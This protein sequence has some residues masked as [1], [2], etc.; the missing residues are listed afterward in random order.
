MAANS[1]TLLLQS[2]AIY[3]GYIRRADYM[4]KTLEK[5]YEMQNFSD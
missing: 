3:N 5:V 1:V 4:K 2:Y